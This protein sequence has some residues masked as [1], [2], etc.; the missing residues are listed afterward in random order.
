MGLGHRGQHG[1]SGGLGLAAVLFFTACGGS[2]ADGS[3]P[4]VEGGNAYAPTAGQG[5]VAGQQA[6][7]GPSTPYGTAPQGQVAGYGQPQAAPTGTTPPPSA[8]SPLCSEATAIVCGG[9]RCNAQVG[10]CAMPCGSAQDCNPGFS[11]LGA[12][13]PTAI[14]VPGGP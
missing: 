9:H 2:Q 4:T 6:P 10:R 13:G 1:F 11:C 8:L 3:P 7:Y 12:G 14:C 5:T